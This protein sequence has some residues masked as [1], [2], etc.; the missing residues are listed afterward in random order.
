MKETVLLIE[1]EKLMRVTLDDALKSA[2]YDV[3]SFEAGTDALNFLKDNSVDVVVTDVRLPDIDGIDILRQISG[4]NDSQVIVMTA[5]GTIKDAVDAMKLGAF[6]YITKPFSLDEFIL[7]IERALDVKR[8]KDE[9]IRLKKDL[10]KCY[11]FPN[12]IGESDAMKKVFSL[13]QKVADSDST[14][15]I[16][17][18][19]G[20][21]KEL[22]ATTIH[23]QSKR[24]D[25]PLIKIN[26]AAMPDGLI[27]SELFGHE[28]GAFTGAIKR[29]PGR[30][31]L[32]NGGTIFLDEIG[33]IPLST[34]AKILRVIQERQF[35]R[36]G[37]TETLNVDVRIIAAT[38]KDLD[39]EVKKGNFRD[40]LYYRLNVIPVTLPP[41][42]ER[43]EDI[44]YLVDF[45]L[46]KCKNKLSR[47]I[48]FSKDAMDI[49]LK[50][51]YPGNIREL[52]NIV[53]RCATLS[54]SDI[55][56]K[57]DLPSFVFEKSDNI[58]HVYLS[59]VAAE[60]EKEHIIRILK[61]TKGNK[62]R[63]AEVLGISRK[64]LWEKMN[65]YGIE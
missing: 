2:G 38:N 5:F 47:N 25:K 50:Y 44:P 33:D 13:I 30:F 39:E 62:T 27:E 9:N 29:K 46:N 11:C 1:D 36:V 51:D 55:I 40:D 22:I 61:T 8:L 48:R 53:E 15:L 43:K 24:K 64:T 10:G 7:L 54:A 60:A 65:L 4:T 23:Y 17:G 20:T 19:S 56:Q 6:D 41:L 18:E 35:E 26:C 42:R 31:E 52:E 14:A 3:V 28:K 45:F 58:K 57:E 12:I 16:L 32:A 49:L 63:A 37:G 34:Q 21:G 59:D